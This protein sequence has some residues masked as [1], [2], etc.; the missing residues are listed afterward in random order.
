MGCLESNFAQQVQSQQR[1]YEQ[2][3]EKN[4]ENMVEKQLAIERLDAERRKKRA[5]KLQRYDENI[6]IHRRSHRLNNTS[7]ERKYSFQHN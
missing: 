2:P 1:V 6:A 5:E 4:W 3:R 7:H